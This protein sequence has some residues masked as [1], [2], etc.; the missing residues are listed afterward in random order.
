MSSTLGTGPVQ[1]VHET[2]LPAALYAEQHG[3]GGHIRGGLE[4][5]PRRQR[6]GDLGVVRQALVK[7]S[8]PSRRPTSARAVTPDGIARAY[9]I[10]HLSA[11]GP[12][13]I[14]PQKPQK[15]S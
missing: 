10:S 9:L 5:R 13:K 3:E 6:P 11:A 15:L 2:A 7:L 1:S 14:E 12:A 8:R 4:V